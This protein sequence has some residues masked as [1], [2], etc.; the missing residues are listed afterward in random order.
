[1]T[2]PRADRLAGPWR[3]AGSPR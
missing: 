3:P 2:C 1:M